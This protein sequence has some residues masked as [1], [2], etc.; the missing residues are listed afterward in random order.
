MHAVARTLSPPD[1]KEAA[2]RRL[3]LVYAARREPAQA[4]E[5]M[6]RSLLLR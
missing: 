1:I 3:G 6:V 4:V 5:H 2:H